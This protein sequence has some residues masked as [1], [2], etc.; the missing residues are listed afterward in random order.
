VNGQVDSVVAVARTY[1][2]RS[3]PA[4]R[5]SFIRHHHLPPLYGGLEPI[6]NI[7]GYFT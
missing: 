7:D 5:T 6:D 3:N 2:K 1:E 4:R